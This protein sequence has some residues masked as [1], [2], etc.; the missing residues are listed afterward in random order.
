MRRVVLI[1][2]LCLLLIFPAASAA[3]SP[4]RAA[5]TNI[6]VGVDCKLPPFQFL[7]DNGEL[8]GMHIDLM[9]EIAQRGNL[10][11]EYVVFDFTGEAVAALNA[12]EVDVVLGVLPSDAGEFT[13][14][15]MTNDISSASLCVLVGNQTLERVLHPELDPRR[16]T[17]AYEFGTISLSR[18]SQLNILYTEIQGNQ[19]QLYDSLVGGEIDAI[20]A[21]KDSVQYL[22]E[23]DRLNQRYTITHNYM[24]SVDYA[25]FVRSTDYILCN[26]I[27]GAINNIR[28][29]SRYEQIRGEWIVDFELETAQAKIQK[30]FTY[31][32]LLAGIAL[33]I[34]VNVG[35]I[36]QR[37]KKLVTEKTR[38]INERMH[39]LEASVTLRNRLIEYSPSGSMLLDGQGNVL[40]MNSVAREMV[41]APGAE[42]DIK[43]YN[44]RD[45][46]IFGPI[47]EKTAPAPGD[48][49]RPP[50]LITL[51]GAPA[52]KYTYRYQYHATSRPTDIVLM[53]EDVTREEREKQEVYEENKNQALNRIITGLAHE[54]KNPLMSIR[55]FA[56]LI[57]D[58]GDDPEFQHS[59]GEFVP[60][61]VDRINSL[62]ES[63]I[64]YARPHR[65]QKGRIEVA[66][67]IR[68]CVNL[69]Q[70]T[71]KKHVELQSE[72]VEDAYL[73]GD[74]D[75]L[76]QAFIN[77]LINSIESVEAKLEARGEQ[78]EGK[79]KVSM[80]AFRRGAE[81]VVEVYDEGAGMSES[82]LQKC[83][84][85]FFTTKKTGTGMGLALARQ[86]VQENG[87]RFEME[88][89]HG[90]YTVIRMIFEEGVGQ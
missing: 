13:D 12:G 69:V 8:A 73:Y 52:A 53:V 41:G 31:I 51:G 79:L 29:S 46:K 68:E 65:G 45:L 26:T 54:I 84:E 64:N 5:K 80:R 58:Q 57:P 25:L 14:L 20:V 6:K 4:Q 62:V 90:R 48:A 32:A 87:G 83:T 39:Q 38:E 30:L 74:K 36:N 15:R 11:V 78:Q 86:F 63:L 9:D 33:I 43:T 76:R 23:R 7:D 75:Q 61:E 28:A 34:I 27:N 67:L 47:W 40:L 71:A 22:L 60:K 85:P 66:Q 3:P 16:Y 55:A 2:L 44:I 24:A 19:M 50:A 18:L 59:F 56:S 77:L 89:V 10:M 88:S 82:D 42:Q 49:A 21:V 70:V 1:I 81:L 17:A 37:L 72:A 35:Y